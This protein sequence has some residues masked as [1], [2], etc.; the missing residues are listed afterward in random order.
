MQITFH[1]KIMTFDSPLPVSEV[2]LYLD[3]KV[4]EPFA[5]AVNNEFVPRS[6]YGQTILKD[7]DEMD[8]VTP[9]QGG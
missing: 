2:L 3:S 9:M 6:Q 1:G 4:A 5:L 7:G 8:L